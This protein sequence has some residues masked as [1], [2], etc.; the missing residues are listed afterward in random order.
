MAERIWQLDQ[1]H[2]TD[3][4]EPFADQPPLATAQRAIGTVREQSVAV[5]T[6]APRP[7]GESAPF[8]LSRP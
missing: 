1:E 8:L 2:S 3:E 6:F 5:P 7:D 4:L